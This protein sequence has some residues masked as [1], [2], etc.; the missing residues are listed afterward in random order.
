MAVGRQDAHTHEVAHLHRLAGL[1]RRQDL[2]GAVDLRCIGVGAAHATLAAESRGRI[3]Q[4]LQRLAHPGLQLG[5]GHLLGHGHEARTPLLAH[6]VGQRAGEVVGARAFDRRVGKTTGTV[7]LGLLHE[8]QQ[9]LKFRLRLARETGD[10]GRA[11]HQLRAGLAPA[12]DALHVLLAVGRALHALEHVGVGM[13]EGHIQIGQH[14][15][16][17]HQRQHLVHMRVGVD[18]VQ[19]HPGTKRLGKLAQLRNE[20]QHP[21]LD[22]LAV[23]ET[24]PV[25]DVHA[26]GRGV[27][28]DD[29]QLL[30]AALEQ[31]AGLVQHIADRAG[32][33]VSAHARDDAEGAAVVAALADLQVRVVLGRQLDAVARHQVHEGVMRLGHMGVHRVHHLLR[34]MRAGH[35]QHAGVDFAHQAAGVAAA[36]TRLGAQA[37]GHDDLAVLGQGLADGVQAFL[38]RVIDEAAGVDDHQVGPGEGLGGFIALGA[39]LRQDQLAVGQ[40]LRA[41]K[42]A[43]RN[44]GHLLLHRTLVIC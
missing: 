18:V 23:P 11:D 29:Q 8:V 31:R 21:R 15:A 6:R 20:V 19:A 4:H 2:D 28:A 35:G 16:F 3:D 7:D 5:G 24:G 36:G 22:R 32:H 1:L 33:Q 26:V 43:E 25:F 12:Q 27:L 42:R 14:Q 37:P 39:Q 30:H 38:D 44:L 9:D 34:R 41:A 13:L 10:E 40:R 17:G